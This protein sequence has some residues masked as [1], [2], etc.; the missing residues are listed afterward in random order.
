[1]DWLEQ[2][3]GDWNLVFYKT[4][5][6]NL[7]FGRNSIP[8]EELSGRL[9]WS[10][11]L[12]H[13]SDLKTLEALI[14]GTSGFLDKAGKDVYFHEL[15]HIWNFLK[16]KHQ[17]TSMDQSTWKFKQSRPANFPSVR[18]SQ[19]AALLHQQ[20]NLFES[21][22]AI[23]CIKDLRPR[24]NF[25]VS[26]YW[27]DHYRFGI[28]SK[29]SRKEWSEK[30]FNLMMINTIIPVLFCFGLQS[31]NE[32]LKKRSLTWLR[33]IPAEDNSVIRQWRNI[34]LTPADAFESQALLH[35][36]NNFCD[37]K[38]CTQCII[39][40]YFIAEDQVVVSR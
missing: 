29:R 12:K 18:L 25:Q 20:A 31:G 1:M 3:A 30:T 27:S 36:K 34:G 21:V 2:S 5:C 37:R 38:S 39:G 24:L 17:I 6:R 15:K 16:H 4:L 28:R 32:G 11:L 40:R 26:Q 14:F 8:F 35:Q 10:V 7:G 33:Q 19:L 9:K 23:K 22:I 13:K